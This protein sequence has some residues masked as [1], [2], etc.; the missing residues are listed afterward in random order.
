MSRGTEQTYSLRAPLR[1]D[2]GSVESKSDPCS[3]FAC[4]R[5]AGQLFP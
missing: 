5:E 3:F 2:F 4:V 1:F